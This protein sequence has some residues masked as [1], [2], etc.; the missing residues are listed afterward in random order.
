MRR[1][2]GLQAKPNKGARMES[3][4]GCKPEPGHSTHSSGAGNTRA[5]AAGVQH[6]DEAAGVPATGWVSRCTA[7]MLGHLTTHSQ[8]ALCIL[9]PPP[10]TLLKEEPGFT[11]AEPGSSWRAAA[12]MARS[13][14]NAHSR[15]LWGG[16]EGGGGVQRRAG[17]RSGWAYSS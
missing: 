10:P 14:P 5:A 7:K 9:K 2:A 1:Q 12:A 8:P 11:C 16:R 4:D 17:W 15:L 6:T 3:E 13:L